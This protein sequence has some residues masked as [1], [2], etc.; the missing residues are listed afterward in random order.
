MLKRFLIPSGF[1][2]PLQMH[3]EVE[4]TVIHEKLWAG[5]SAHPATEAI[6]F[7]SHFIGYAQHLRREGDAMQRANVEPVSTLLG[8]E[9]S[10]P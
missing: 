7:S 5:N 10:R 8:G 4:W 6:A 3:A 2:T 9:G 1:I